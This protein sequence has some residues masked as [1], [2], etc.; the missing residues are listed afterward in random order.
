MGTLT[1][2]DF[3]RYAAELKAQRPD[4]KQKAAYQ[5]WLGEV[6]RAANFLRGTNPAFDKGRFTTA[7]GA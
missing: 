6:E 7:C 2:K 1:R 3:N 5:R 4:P